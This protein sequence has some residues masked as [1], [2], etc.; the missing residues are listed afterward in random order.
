[1]R[2]RGGFY[3]SSMNLD[4]F[5]IDERA[6]A[7]AEQRREAKLTEDETPIE[8]DNDCGDACTILRWWYEQI[9]RL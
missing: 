6:L 8:A 4:N 3:G 1:M 7:E 5:D 2:S 9:S